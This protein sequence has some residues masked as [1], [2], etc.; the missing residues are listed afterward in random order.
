MW[1]PGPAQPLLAD[2][3]VHVW[4]AELDRTSEQVLE[5]LSV[6]ERA[7]ASG[8]LDKRTRMRWMSSRGVLRALL[9]SYLDTD[10]S[11]LR[12][13]TGAH[14]KP[15]LTATLDGAQAISFNLSHSAEVALYALAP[16][17]AVGV[18]IEHAHR[19]SVDAVA[20]AARM[21]GPDEAE[22][23]RALAPPRREREFLRA[24]VRHEAQLKCRGVG[25]G[26]AEAH[27]ER[28]QPPWV[29]QLE[30]GERWFAAVS[31]PTPPR[32]LRCWRWPALTA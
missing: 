7:R 21:F 1:A 22:R 28:E 18:D 13:S 32:E 5:L 24:W 4:R 23:L 27:D 16:H 8:V 20:V 3:E 11:V 9:G 30:M 2:G 26:G 17:G 19:R 31:A 29:S 25:I 14:G 10:A 6:E 12:F 15:A